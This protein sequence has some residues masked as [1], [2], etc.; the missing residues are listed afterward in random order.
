[1]HSTVSAMALAQRVGE[2]ERNGYTVFRG[3]NADWIERW[4]PVF[5][6]HYRRQLGQG[7]FGRG[8]GQPRAVLRG[9]LQEYPDLFVPSLVAPAMLDFLEG[10]MGPT[11]GFDSLQI[12]ITPPVSEREARR[13]HAWHRDMWALT[14]WTRDYL[15]PNA[16]NVLSYLQ[17]GPEYGELRVIPGSHR[18]SRV[19]GEGGSAQAQKGQQVVPIAA[20]DT[21]VIHSSLL[22]TTSGNYSGELRIFASFFYTRAWLPKRESYDG[23]AMQRVIRTARQ[24][25]DRRVARLFEPDGELLARRFNGNN[26]EH[27][28]RQRWQQWLAEEGLERARAAVAREQAS[29]AATPAK[30]AAPERPQA[31][32]PAAADDPV[33]TAGAVAAEGAAGKTD[34]AREETSDGATA[35]QDAAPQR[36][37]APLPA[38][39]ADPAAAAEAV[40]TDAAAGNPDAAREEASG[41]PTAGQDA[42]LPRAQAPQPAAAANPVAVAD[43]AAATAGNTNAAP[44]AAAGIAPLADRPANADSVAMPVLNA[45]AELGEGPV[46]DAASGILYWVD[47][48]AGVVH[49]YR[50]ISGL[51]G[52]VEVDEIIGCVVPRQSGGL[53]A[54]TASGIYH[55]DSDTGAKTRVSAID[56]DRPETHFN[57]G[58]VDPAGRFWF[59][60]IAVDRT[61]DLLGD[62]YSLEPDLTVT[63]RLRGVDN[64]NGMDWSPD[65]RT[66]YYIDSLTRQV[67][68]YDYDAATGAIANPRPIV[69]LPA[70]TGVPDGMTVSVDGSLWV[71]HWGGARVTRWHPD[72][73]ALLQTIAVPANLTTSCAFAGPTMDELY[74]T[75]AR[76]QEPIAALAAQPL[77]GGLFRYRTDTRGRPAAVFPG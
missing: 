32:Q 65:G 3:F 71:A 20:G 62:L 76:Y 15:P 61:T 55:L 10:L 57:D 9:L 27:T 69:T 58:K 40:A 70:G 51:T 59:G 45:R 34:V 8:V 42:A 6:D 56:A 23:E 30:D 46:W 31:S 38:A 60:S 68:A 18:G 39:H 53:L 12:A 2:F 52:S 11:V 5:M 47:L 73:G 48:F 50:P 49:S 66:M 75:T 19:V 44:A 25:G 1:M 72:S 54:A 26:G 16:V 43:A 37:P 28:E 41:G 7:Q 63:H 29:D 13:V 22:H 36:P 33:A 17:E 21:V 14:G 24:Q 77:A 4:R 67:T 64:T 35:G 74:I